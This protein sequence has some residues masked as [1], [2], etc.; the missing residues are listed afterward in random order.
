GG[1]FPTTMEGGRP[2]T[3]RIRHEFHIGTRAP[4]PGEIVR[5]PYPAVSTDT[6]H[7][8]LTVRDREGDPRSEIPADTW[9]FAD[10]ESIR[11]LPSGSR[12]ARFR[13]Y[14]LWYEATGSQVL[15]IGFAAVRD[16]VSFLRHEATDRN[17]AANP[18]IAAGARRE[19]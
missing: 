19:G 5:L 12:F 7:A 16:L 13:I 14:E 8:R 10:A 11:L 18:M 17:G 1:R 3:G 15:G 4:G 2:I 9:E 6:R